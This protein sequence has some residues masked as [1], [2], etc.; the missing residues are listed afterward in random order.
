MS[1]VSTCSISGKIAYI[2]DANQQ[3]NQISSWSIQAL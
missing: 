1:R 3:K 2:I